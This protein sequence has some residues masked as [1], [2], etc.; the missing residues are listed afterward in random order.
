V[1][2][3]GPPIANELGG[4]GAGKHDGNQP[5]CPVSQAEPLAFATRPRAAVFQVL[6]C[7]E[8]QVIRGLASPPV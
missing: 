6:A 5:R 3:S 2:G 8:K 1:T 7:S 4:E